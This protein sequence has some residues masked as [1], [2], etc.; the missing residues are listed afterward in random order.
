MS[1]NIPAPRILKFLQPAQYASWLKK[2]HDPEWTEHRY[3]TAQEIWEEVLK[4][5]RE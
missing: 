4:Q 3:R 1:E 5:E 2:A